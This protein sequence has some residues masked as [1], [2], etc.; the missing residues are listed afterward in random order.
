M[1]KVFGVFRRFGW[2]EA[3]ER[4]G[5]FCKAR[6]GGAVVTALRDMSETLEARKELRREI[7][8]ILSGVVYT[9]WIVLFIGVGAVLAMNAIA[10]GTLCLLYTSDAADE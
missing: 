8:T 7:R 3:K 6:A 4:P 10:P 1:S 5:A 9:S 2:A